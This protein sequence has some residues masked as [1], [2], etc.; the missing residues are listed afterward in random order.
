M[1]KIGIT[2]GIGSGKTTVCKI[3][4][5]L[6]IPVF[7]ADDA[8]KTIM[9]TDA[10]LKMDIIKVF[11]EQ[12]YSKEGELNRKY[13]SLIVFNNEQEL[14]KLNALVH[15]AVF[16]AFEIWVSEQT[17]APYVI[18]EAAL[19]FESESHKMCDQTVLVRSPEALRI[20][21]ILERDGISLAEVRLRM[22]RQLTD[23]KKQELADYVILN[24]ERNLL[25][26]QVLALHQ[27]FLTAGS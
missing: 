23:E 20:R 7:Y 16:K 27:H 14:N 19:L 13:L 22:K 24:D 3:Y 26:P 21:R 9:H 5:V 10:L 2:G 6:G 18:K 15:P 8:A 25:I 17:E 1:F 12:S 11:G 4:E